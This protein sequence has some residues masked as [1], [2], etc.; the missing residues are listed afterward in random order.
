MKL[1]LE[2]GRKINEPT[3]QDIREAIY[4]EEF[5]ILTSNADRY[6][7]CSIQKEPP[8]LHSLEYQDGSI[9]KHFR[10]DRPITPEQTVSAFLKYFSGDSAWQTDF[11]WENIATEIRENLEWQKN[12]QRRSKRADLLVMALV[13]GL[14]AWI[15]FILMI[16]K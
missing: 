14:V 9:D 16:A 11:R 5:V 12:Y 1:I 7:Q 10:A 15:I 8:F 6:I 2:S 4:S 3:E 13:L